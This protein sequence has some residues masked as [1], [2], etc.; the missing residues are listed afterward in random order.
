M[1]IDSG[2]VREGQER[3]LKDQTVGSGEW[4]FF[5]PGWEDWEENP[6]N[7]LFLDGLPLSRGLSQR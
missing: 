2:E 4:C 1:V 5:F 6:G 3:T 7:D